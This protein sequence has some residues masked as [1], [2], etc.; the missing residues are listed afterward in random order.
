MFSCIRDSVIDTR[1]SSPAVAHTT[2][3]DPLDAQNNIIKLPMVVLQNNNSVPIVV[4][5]NNNNVP[6]VVGKNNNSLPIMVVPIVVEPVEAKS[7]T[8][9]TTVAKSKPD[10]SIGVEP[11]GRLELTYDQALFYKYSLTQTLIFSIQSKCRKTQEKFTFQ[12][13]T[14]TI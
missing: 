13:M 7:I 14:T 2:P 8:D 6:I 11:C 5:Q 4:E 1:A 3:V 12:T 9:L 10:L